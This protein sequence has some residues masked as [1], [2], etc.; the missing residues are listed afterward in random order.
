MAKKKVKKKEV[1]MNQ[2][3]LGIMFGVSA[4]SF[5][6]MLADVGLREGRQPTE[7]A[8]QGHLTQEHLLE[9]GPQKGSSF[10][11]W[12]RDK[13]CEVLTENGYVIISPQE[14]RSYFRKTEAKA[15]LRRN[16]RYLNKKD[17]RYV[18]DCILNGYLPY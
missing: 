2:T 15:A 8:L 16:M 5:G 11:L 3:E 4:I 10:W 17:G 14:Q 6:K 18:A 1:W 12:S 9:R 13:V 7:K